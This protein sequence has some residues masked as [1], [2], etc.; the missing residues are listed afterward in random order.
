[1]AFTPGR[2]NAADGV[3]MTNWLSYCDGELLA[4][5]ASS[6]ESE[7]FQE[8]V[9]RHGAMVFRTC[10]RI[11]G[12]DADAEDAMQLVFAALIEKSPLLT[13]Y[14]SAGGWL[15]STAW[16]TANRFLR[17]TRARQRHERHARRGHLTE[18]A[19]HDHD[20]LMCE[21]YRA[22]EMLPRDYA[23]AI[24]LHHLQ[25]YTIEQIA[26]ITL[27][28]EGT[29]AS[30]LSRGRAMIRERL[31]WRGVTI[32]GLTFAWAMGEHLLETMHIPAVTAPAWSAE[33]AAA[34][35]GNGVPLSG[36]VPS[37]RVVTVLFASRAKCACLAASLIIGG[38][39]VAAPY[40]SQWT[41]SRKVIR[42]KAEA[43]ESRDAKFTGA[44]E[45]VPT[46]PVAVPE[47]GSV[48]MIAVAGLLLRRRRR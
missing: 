33:I 3:H 45:V 14:R 11:V 16:H 1:M 7:P 28:G 32:S 10:R 24:V 2:D 37:T 22:I 12:N 26:E 6:G 29:V 34:V 44:E 48:S 23:E 18:T 42:A 30:R 15:Y 43:S 4:A 36:V 9:R 27:C 38:G 20:E 35:A 19:T 25:G 46:V 5:F 17:A 13:S 31:A 8:L 41:E 39:A 47:P 21:I 40:F